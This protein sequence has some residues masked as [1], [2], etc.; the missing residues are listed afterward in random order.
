MF[1]LIDDVVCN[2]LLLAVHLFNLN[3]L[4]KQLKPV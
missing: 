3:A 4:A 1:S 2:T